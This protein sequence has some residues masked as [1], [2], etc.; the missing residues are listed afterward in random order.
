LYCQT[1]RLHA[2]IKG[3]DMAT[4]MMKM[5]DG[6]TVIC[7]LSYATR[8]EHDRFPET[9]I[10]VEGEHGFLELG[11]DFW[12]RETTA[13]GTHAVRYKPPHYPWAD[14]AY[15]LVHSSIVTCQL[16]LARALKGLEVGETS[17]E[18]NLKTVRLVYGAYESAL[19]GRVLYGDEL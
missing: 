10:E 6:A 5:G 18:D 11:P 19:T 3:E 2:D 1:H 9:Y 17:G 14:P 16:N 7:E 13:A 8:R 12:I 15:D 4:V